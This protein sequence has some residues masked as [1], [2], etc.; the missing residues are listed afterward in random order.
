V[1][2]HSYHMDSIQP[3]WTASKHVHASCNSYHVSLK[4]DYSADCPVGPLIDL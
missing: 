4:D 2:T 3:E 1:S